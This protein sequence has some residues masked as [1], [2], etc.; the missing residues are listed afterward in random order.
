M[1]VAEVRAD[2]VPVGLL[3]DQFEGDEVHQNALEAVA[4]RSG[5]G[6]GQGHMRGVHGL[7]THVFNIMSILKETHP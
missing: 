5:C 3:A 4:Q 6:E 1:E 2:D 7:G